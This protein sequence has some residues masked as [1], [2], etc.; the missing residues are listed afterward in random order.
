MVL[1]TGTRRLSIANHSLL[2]SHIDYAST[3][4][5]DSGDCSRVWVAI[6]VNNAVECNLVS[7][8]YSA[9]CAYNA[10]YYLGSAVNIPPEDDLNNAGIEA[11]FVAAGGDDIEW[12]GSWSWDTYNMTYNV[13]HGFQ[14]YGSYFMIMYGYTM[15]PCNANGQNPAGCGKGGTNDSSTCTNRNGS[16]GYPIWDAGE[17]YNVSYGIGNDVPLPQA[18]DGV[19][20]GQAWGTVDS[21][22][23]NGSCSDCINGGGMFF[24]G[25]MSGDITTDYPAWQDPEQN[26]YNFFKGAGYPNQ[27]DFDWDTCINSGPGY[28]GGYTYPCY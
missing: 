22:S 8:G 17:M 15:T 23:D 25:V 7:G 20:W 10:G 28:G 14:E 21:L 2:V 5:N 9:S 16:C 19:S 26:Y 4:F 1:R 24:W 3:Y 18:Y 27:N 12:D 6:G 11:Q 13:L